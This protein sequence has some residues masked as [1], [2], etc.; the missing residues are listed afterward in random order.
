MVLWCE[1]VSRLAPCTHPG[2]R[3]QG[4]SSQANSCKFA[5]LCKFAARYNELRVQTLGYQVPT[6]V[7]VKSCSASG[8]LSVD[9]CSNAVALL[10][11]IPNQKDPKNMAWHLLKHQSACAASEYGMHQRPVPLKPKWNQCQNP[12]N[13]GNEGQHLNIVFKSGWINVELL[14]PDLSRLAA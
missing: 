8:I 10:Y 9:D 1:S 12:C 13:A 5:C 7:W 11:P 6:H 14:R 4:L 3:F 2:W